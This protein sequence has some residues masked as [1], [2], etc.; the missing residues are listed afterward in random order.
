[1]YL[2]ESTKAKPMILQ[3]VRLKSR[4]SEEA[5]MQKAREREPQ[6]RALPGLLQKYYVKMDA[7]GQYGGVYVW[8]SRESLMEFRNSDLAA[9]IPEAYEVVEAPDIEILDILFKL[10]D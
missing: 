6:F 4:L 9:G 1:M 7:P 3:F 8:D 2:E 5:L 10:R